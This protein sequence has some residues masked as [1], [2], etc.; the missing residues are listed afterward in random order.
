MGNVITPSLENNTAFDKNVK[1]ILADSLVTATAYDGTMNDV[2]MRG[3][4]T[5]MS[6]SGVPIVLP[7]ADG[8]IPVDKDGNTQFIFIPFDKSQCPSDIYP[9][10][11][12]HPDGS[13]KCSAFYDAYCN[14]IWNNSCNAYSGSDKRYTLMPDCNCLNSP[15][16]KDPTISAVSNQPGALDGH[17]F[18]NSKIGWRPYMTANIYE[19]T[20]KSITLCQSDINLIK[21]KIG[22]SVKIKQKPAQACGNNSDNNN[23][24]NKS[25]SGNN[26]GGDSENKS[27]SGGG[28][29]DD[30]KNKSKSGGGSGDDSKNK[31]IEYVA[32]GGS[33]LLV[34]ILIIIMI[35]II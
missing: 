14:T 29:G 10:N 3:C 1:S 18:E 17:C 7:N 4:C 24:E 2:L 11:K 13:S 5:G 28:S 30:S 22:G 19:Q 12:T 32:I 31:L 34:C 25:E 23:S 8:T 20:G 9:T 15:F 16:E 21:D 6:S 33:L 26:S 35:I 27:E